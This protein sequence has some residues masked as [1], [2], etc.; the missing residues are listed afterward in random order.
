MHGH[1]LYSVRH[2]LVVGLVLTES[3][4]DIA[5][6]P[7]TVMIL[8][9]AEESQRLAEPNLTRQRLQKLA[10]RLGGSR[11][12]QRLVR[13]T[14]EIVKAVNKQIIFVPLSELA[15]NVSSGIDGTGTPRVKK[16]V[17]K[18]AV[19]QFTIVSA[20]IC[21]RTSDGVAR[22]EADP[23]SN[24]QQHSMRYIVLWLDGDREHR[25]AGSAGIFIDDELLPCRRKRHPFVAK[26]LLDL[27]RLGPCR[28]KQ[29]HDLRWV[30]PSG[31]KSSA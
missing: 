2:Q 7:Q 31:D 8:C 19:E 5:K 12:V 29:D 15:A 17:R 9:G 21:D 28:R 18:G 6:H 1:E 14:T 13:E 10:H 26:R 30:Y 25:M 23:S 20:V 27:A 11:L 4:S 24:P 3:V 16:A 22:S